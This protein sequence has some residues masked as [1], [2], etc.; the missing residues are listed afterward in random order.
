ESKIIRSHDVIW[1][2]NRMYRDQ[3]HDE[4][5]PKEELVEDIAPKNELSGGKYPPT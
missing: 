1:R 5:N 4:K 2:E 3:V